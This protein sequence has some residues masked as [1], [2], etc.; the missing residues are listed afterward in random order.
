MKQK[1]NGFLNS[2]GELNLLA[3]CFKCRY[4]IMRESVIC[5]VASIYLLNSKQVS[6]WIF[7]SRQLNF[8]LFYNYVD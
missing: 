3:V 6:M 1:I 2:Q 8:V 5:K 4:E 7:T